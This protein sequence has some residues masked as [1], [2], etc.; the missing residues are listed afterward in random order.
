MRWQER[1]TLLLEAPPSMNTTF[2]LLNGTVLKMK[3]REFILYDA[4][5]ND[6]TTIK[7]ICV[8]SLFIRCIFGFETI[9]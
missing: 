9:Y 5:D 7:L 4:T 8:E 3:I 2:F 1:K 6:I